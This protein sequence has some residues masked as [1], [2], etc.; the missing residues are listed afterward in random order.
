MQTSVYRAIA[1]FLILFVL[2][3][4]LC[5]CVTT[6]PLSKGQPPKGI[7][8][9]E[10]KKALS[11]ASMPEPAPEKAHYLMTAYVKQLSLARI[12][13]EKNTADNIMLRS[14]LS[15]VEGFVA[16]Q[17]ESTLFEPVIIVS[18]HLKKKQ[19]IHQLIA[20]F[21]MSSHISEFPDLLEVLS[22]LQETDYTLQDVHPAI[23]V[24]LPARD[25]K[26]PA[27]DVAQTK[28]M[29]EREVNMLLR[30][31]S[32]LTD[33]DEARVQLSLLRFFIT[34]HIRD[35]AY[36]AAENAKQSLAAAENNAKDFSAI[37]EL[38]AELDRL[39]NQLHREM[40]FTIKAF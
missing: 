34:F 30:D 37:N 29:L 6:P 26:F 23:L 20:P 28:A 4:A 31:R 33:S 21:K 3:S 12:M 14:R 27:N 40:P 18:Y 10:A 39:E 7:V 11:P 38:S 1:P 36:L 13:A 19:D 35:A 8:K 32:S 2:L 22:Q 9:K 24:N 25:L 5:S 17:Q 15:A 16:E